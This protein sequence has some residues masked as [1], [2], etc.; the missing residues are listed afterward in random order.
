MLFQRIKPALCLVVIQLYLPDIFLVEAFSNPSSGDSAASYTLFDRFR[1][2]CPANPHS[3]NQFDPS[4]LP[5]DTVGDKDEESV[6][7]AVFR[8]SNNKPSVFVRDEF[9]NAMRLATGATNMESSSADNEFI[10]TRSEFQKPKGLT[11]PSSSSTFSSSSP[12]FL[13]PTSTTPVAVARLRPSEDIS[14]TWV[15][16]KM[17]CS[18][19]KENQDDACEGGSEHKEALSVAMDALLL[20]HLK[21]HVRSSKEVSSSSSSSDSVSR[22]FEGAI[23]SKATLI[24]ASLL[25][26][27]GFQPVQ[28]LSRDM[29]THISSLD[30]SMERY[31][32]KYVET[33]ATKNPGARERAHQILSLLGRLDREAEIRVAKQQLQSDNENGDEDDDYDPWASIK[34]FGL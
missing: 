16:D 29:A 21:L 26:E 17:Q 8:T 32:E 1:P 27:R 4:L 18:L 31:A 23:R 33:S 28:K 5:E 30:K 2:E 24:A 34:Q 11:A 25:E 14:S 9:L 7:V 22:I 3:I 13:G 6:W 15:L 19:K 20:H 12:S 10:E